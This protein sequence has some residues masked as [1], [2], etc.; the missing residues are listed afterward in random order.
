MLH[1]Q[2]K[3]QNMGTQQAPFQYY[4][5]IGAQ[6]QD[7]ETSGSRYQGIL[8]PQYRRQPPVVNRMPI[9]PPAIMGGMGDSPFRVPQFS[10]PSRGS[11]INYSDYYGGGRGSASAGRLPEPNAELRSGRL[12]PPAPNRNNRSLSG[13]NQLLQMLMGGGG[14]S[15]MEIL[16]MLMSGAGGG[17]GASGVGGMQGAGG[18]FNF[19][20]V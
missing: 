3:Q 7:Q 19:P 2:H 13:N 20:Y 18:G 14:G 17:G 16:K 6:A 15:M 1:S 12:T 8:A 11:A 4:R 10:T 5:Q 9:G